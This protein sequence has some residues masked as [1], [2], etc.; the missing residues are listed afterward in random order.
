MTFLARIAAR[1]L[2]AQGDGV[3]QLAPKDRGLSAMRAAAS[4]DEMPEEPMQ[5][6]IGSASRL[7]LRRA[8]AT[9]APAPSKDEDDQKK[10]EQPAQAVRRAVAEP[11]A[12]ADE[13]KASRQMWRAAAEPPEVDEE[14]DT[15]PVN[16]ATPPRAEDP[17][18]DDRELPD[19]TRH[20]KDPQKVLA[21]HAI[22]RDGLGPAG[23]RAEVSVPFGQTMD[24]PETGADGFGIPEDWR[25]TGDEE[26]FSRVDDD[27]PRPP[28][29]IVFGPDGGGHQSPPPFPGLPA[30][31]GPA[32]QSSV[33]IEQIDV[34][35][36]EPAPREPSRPRLSDPSCMIAARYLRRL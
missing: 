29:P 30:F 2:G 18:S 27:L 4:A 3:P 21:K 6:G 11:Q 1:A 36:Q 16:R 10:E 26:G 9:P 35:V 13:Q 8:P 24:R 31:G 32:E 19:Q 12:E 23:S 15:A 7:S 17:P 25:P 5:A 33:V 34:F 22:R 20:E 28:L 14:K